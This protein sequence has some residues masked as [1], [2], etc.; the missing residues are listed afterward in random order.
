MSGVR[1]E[2]SAVSAA[3]AGPEDLRGWITDL[4]SDFLYYDRRNN[5]EL[6]TDDTRACRELRAGVWLR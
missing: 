1:G 2:R 6:P 5:E 3:I 4:V